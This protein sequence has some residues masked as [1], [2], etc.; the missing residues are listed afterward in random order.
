[1]FKLDQVALRKLFIFFPM[2][3]I[4]MFFSACGSKPTQKPKVV[5]V[6]VLKVE[7]KDTPITIE[8]VAQTQSSHLV[9]IQA[10]VN[11]FL[12][13]RVYTEGEFV[14][15]GQVLFIMDKK[16]F[17]AQVSASE[18]ALAKQKAA[19]NTAQ[20]NLA[21]IKP[22]VE[23]K[24]LS[25][26]DLDDATGTYEST[27]ALVNQ[28]EAELETANLNL[29]YTTITSPIDGV[30]SSALQQEG[31]YINVND[32]K[33]TTVS[34]LDPI[35]VNF[36]ISE[37]QLLDF[38]SKFDKGLLLKPKNDEYEVEIVLVDGT[39]FPYTGRITFAEPYY[40]SQTG[41]FLIRAS[42]KNPDKFLRPNQFVRARIKGAIKPKAIVVP[43]RAVQQSTKGHFVWVVD[44]DGK[45]EMRPVSVGDWK[46]EDWF[47]ND[48]L[49]AG[50]LVI[51]DGTLGLS[52]GLPVIIK[53]YLPGS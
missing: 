31:T 38:R 41:T 1:M 49:N 36:S 51:V 17:Q 15:E 16:P 7:E 42:V 22:L 25:Q 33:L 37:N 35:W 10:R 45:V 44:T 13:K 11:G 12:E 52:A 8:Y 6:D 19:L 34:T 9:N 46:G 48:G 23:K 29:S 27:S 26:K 21:R 2:A 18:A 43:Q 20:L 3:A 39:I 50:D 40:N 47:I 5:E 24:A 53:S 32:S 28:A 30:T 14:K 4:L